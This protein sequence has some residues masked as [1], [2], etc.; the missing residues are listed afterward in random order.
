[1]ILVRSQCAGPDNRSPTIDPSIDP[2]RY[3]NNDPISISIIAVV[4]LI[5][6]KTIC[7]KPPA[8]AIWYYK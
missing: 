8:L 5:I 2:S 6:N 4:E 7:Y 3:R 1:M